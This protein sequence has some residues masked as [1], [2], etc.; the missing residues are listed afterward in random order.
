LTNVTRW[1]ELIVTCLGLTPDDVIVI[2]A[3]VVEPPPVPPP[4][5][6]PPLLPPSDGLVGELPP[7]PH[8]I[9]SASNDAHASPASEC[10]AALMLPPS[11]TL[12]FAS[13]SIMQD[14]GE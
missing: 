9:A 3:S 14:D 10:L 8:A 13:T 5:V 6:P 11:L 1:P 4:P 7:P 2:V 12:R